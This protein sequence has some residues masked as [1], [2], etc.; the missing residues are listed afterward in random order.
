MANKKEY[1]K[2]RTVGEIRKLN[3]SESYNHKGIIQSIDDLNPL[4]NRKEREI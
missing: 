4:K 3:S 2:E 1:F